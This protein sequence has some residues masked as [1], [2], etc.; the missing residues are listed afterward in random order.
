MLKKSILISLFIAL[1]SIPVLADE[2]GEITL[3]E[4][5]TLELPAVVQDEPAK[6]P[7]QS[8]NAPKWEEFCESGYENAKATDK[9][10]ILNVINFVDAERTKSNYWAERRVNFEKA[11]EHCNTL[12]EEEKAFCY[13]GVR[14]AENERNEMY[15]IQRKHINY[16]NQGIIIDKPNY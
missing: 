2:Q 4:T 11:I 15:E 13:E 8:V 7:V 3:D 9:K 10:N 12:T 14:N 5:D 1:L 6:P 16:K